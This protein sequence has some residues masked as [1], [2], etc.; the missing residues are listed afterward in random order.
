[1]HDVAHHA[2]VSYQTVSRVVNN[3][4]NVAAA[5]RERVLQVIQALNYRPSLVA[6]GLVTRRSGLIGIV[7]YGTGQYGPARIVQQVEQA[8]RDRGYEVMLTTLRAFEP[9]DI[10]AAVERLRQFGVDGL[11]LLTPLDAHQAVAAAGGG[12]P[13]VMIDATR[14]VEGPSVSIDQFEGA[15]LATEHLAGLGHRRILHVAGPSEWSDAELR[16]QGYLDV[17]I[18]RGLPALARQ[19]GD[20][21][22][23]SGHMALLRALDQGEQF[24][25][26]FSANDQ[27]ALGVMAALTSK[28]LRVPGDVSVVGFDDLPEAAFYSPPL[29]TV[30]QNL[31]VL[32]RK[33][34]DELMRLIASNTGRPRQYLFQPN[35]IVRDS[36]AVPARNMGESSVRALDG[37]R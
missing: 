34:V 5:T 12:C 27:M 29:T 9:G 10:H 17:V 11:V 30:Q 21:S 32:G 13:F 31:E 6:K 1:M 2:G 35:L 15:R 33:A 24:T 37:R 14:E 7:A 20:W 23:R 8:C 18:G 3:Q 28:G 16:W 26:V 22:A 36:T 25:A 4:A 19:A